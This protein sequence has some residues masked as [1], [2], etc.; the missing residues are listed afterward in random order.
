M[1]RIAAA[2]VLLLIF[3][4]P[5]RA[6]GPSFDCSRTQH[7]I[8]DIICHDETLAAKDRRL[9]EIYRQ[10]LKAV[11]GVA[12]KV[13]AT[14][15]LKA[16]QRGWIKGRNDCWKAEDKAQCASDNY[17]MRIAELQ[18]RYF[19]LKGGDPVFYVCDNNP[20]NE[21]VATYIPSDL[22]SVRLERGDTT[23]IGIL[24]PSASGSKY[25]A[26]FGIAFQVQGDGAKVDWPQG[27]SFACKQRQ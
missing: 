27:T 25:V 21:I 9:V 14:K 23:V 2:A 17:D 1:N 7:E 5:A 10:A 18:A 8:E 12:D 11:G 3:A 6:E 15:L 19:L 16:T 24:S 13:K 26:D 22:P 20:A 4:L